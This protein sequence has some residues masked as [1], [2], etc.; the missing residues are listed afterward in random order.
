MTRVLCV[1]YAK[2]VTTS[3]QQPRVHLAQYYNGIN[4]LVKHP[5]KALQTFA[6]NAPKHPDKMG[7]G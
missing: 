2:S 7:G 4:E 1:L 5:Y 3:R 6:K